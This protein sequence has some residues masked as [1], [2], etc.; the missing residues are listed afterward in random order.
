MLI[1]HNNN[2]FISILTLLIENNRN[3]SYYKTDVENA[4]CLNQYFVSYLFQ[5]L[6][7]NYP[8]CLQNKF[9]IT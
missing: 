3:D 2:S 7:I 8:L 6:V 1:K 4:T 5:E 9:I